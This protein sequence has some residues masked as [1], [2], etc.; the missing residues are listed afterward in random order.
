MGARQPQATREQIL[1]A[2][3]QSVYEHGLFGTSLDSVLARTRV[4]KGALYH[5]FECKQALG[6]ALID[7]VVAARVRA[8]WVEPLIGTRDPIAK[9]Q[10]LIR[11]VAKEVPEEM[12]RFGCPLNNLAQEISALDEQLRARVKAIFSGWVEE[13]QRALRRGQRVGTVR[14]DV[15]VERAA[16]FVV[17]AIEG[18]LSLGKTTR[19]GG[20]LRC[21]L[22]ELATYLESLR[23]ARPARTPRQRPR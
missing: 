14:A 6:R 1:Q 16:V 4:T 2:A 18:A 13:L 5:H 19:D 9:L 23:P 10:G 20:V 8:T 22:E 15:E 12:L 3:F 7:E 17:G 21:A 11:A